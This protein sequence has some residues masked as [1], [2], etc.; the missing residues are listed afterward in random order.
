[1]DKSPETAIAGAGH[2]THGAISDGDSA[3][4]R[5]EK[6][7]DALPASGDAVAV[8]EEDR[9]YPPTSK[10]ILIVLSIAASMFLVALVCIPIPINRW[11][12]KLTLSRIKTSSQPPYPG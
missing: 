12:Q 5:T 3:L 8:Q 10:A 11:A 4:L 2:G 9:I 7:A 6:Q 1:M